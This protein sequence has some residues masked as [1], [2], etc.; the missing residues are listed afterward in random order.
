MP[1]KYDVLG[2]YGA[3]DDNDEA[4]VKSSTAGR[5]PSTLTS[6][7]Q[8]ALS[9]AEMQRRQSAA[10]QRVLAE[11]SKLD[12]TLED[13]QKSAQEVVCSPLRAQAY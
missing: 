11:A 8:T 12:K 2:P 4:A 5:S 6:R 7:P 1:S 3:A 9:E 10:A 13:W